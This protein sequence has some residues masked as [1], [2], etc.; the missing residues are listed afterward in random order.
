MLV[1]FRQNSGEFE[2]SWLKPLAPHQYQVT[3]Y[4]TSGLGDGLLPV[5]PWYIILVR[6]N[7]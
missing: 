2:A 5:L 6:R 1:Q 4:F 7:F 3:L